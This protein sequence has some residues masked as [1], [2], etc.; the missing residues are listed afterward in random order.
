MKARRHGTQL[1]ACAPARAV[2]A[3]ATRRSNQKPQAF[4]SSAGQPAGRRMS[5]DTRPNSSDEGEPQDL[6][7]GLGEFDAEELRRQ[8]WL[9][10]S[11]DPV[12]MYLQE[13]GR[14][15]LLSAEEEIALAIDIRAGQEAEK[16]LRKKLYQKD[17]ERQELERAVTAGDIA[18]RR[19]ILSNLR[20][21]VSVAKRYV[22]R[23][24][25]LLDLIQ[26]GNMGL[27]RAVERFDPNMGNKFSTYAIWWIR[28]AVTRAIADQARIIRVPVHVVES[29]N[30]LLQVQRRLLQELG[31]EPTTEEIA[32]EMGFLSGSDLQAVQQYRVRG[33]EPPAE[34]R[35]HLCKALNKVR[36]IIQV[37]QEPLSLE[38]PVD[39][40]QDSS[41][42]D[43]IED[44]AVQAPADVA[45]R[46]LLREQMQEMLTDLTER[47]R[48]VLELRFGL[49]DGQP[50][51]LE[52]VGEALGVTRERIR[53]IE[54]KA[55]EKLRHL[56]QS[57]KLR[58]YLM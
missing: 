7:D 20:L 4:A 16:R 30:R 47:E 13:I 42:G 46:N 49:A 25:S 9:G 12:Y 53:Q 36:Q 11:E 43:F 38:T 37:S 56:D 19:L 5:R 58:D 48:Q 6:L 28:Q 31:R 24:M 34:L 27:L 21:V 41:L 17:E 55:L 10:S 45:T 52:E 54:I 23:G 33:E 1:P 35:R 57:R 2:Q 26:E 3:S 51:T 44:R 32:L 18:Q 40:E 15:P 22:G 8:A 50:H 29:I 14:V 39:T